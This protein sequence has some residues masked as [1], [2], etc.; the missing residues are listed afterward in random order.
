MRR[1]TTLL[2]RYV[3]VGLLAAAPA[4]AA[5]INGRIS[6]VDYQFGDYG[7]LA[8]ADTP[9]AVP[10]VVAPE[11]GG[12]APVVPNVPQEDQYQMRA[13]PP[14]EAA[15]EAEEGPTRYLESGFSEATGIKTYGWV[16][17]GIGANNWGAPFNGPITFDDRN[18]QG[19][20]NQL[21]L[22]NEK[23]L[24]TECSWF[25]WGGRI[26]LLYGTDYVFTT[27]RGLDAYAAGDP[28]GLGAPKWGNRYSGLAMPQLYGEFG[29]GDLAVKFGH[30]Y[31]II[32]YEVVP[33][34]GNFFYTHAYTMQYGEPFTHTGVLTTWTPNEQIVFYNG[35]TN[36]WDNWDDDML[37][38]GPIINDTYPGATS[39]AAYLGGVT[40]KN[41][42][43]SQSLTFTVTSGNEVQ[44]AII[45]GVVGNRSLYSLVYVNELNDCWTYVLQH[46]N[47]WQFNG[48]TPDGVETAQW[49]GINQYLFRTLNDCWT[50]GMRLEWFRDNDGT[51]VISGLRNSVAGV[52]SSAT[53]FEGNFWELTWGLNYKPNANWMVRPELRYDW[54]SPDIGYAGALPYGRG[55]NE[56]GQLYGGCDVIWQF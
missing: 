21:Y 25:D 3:A 43:A 44:N 52:P 46:D 54:F 40:F 36:G 28:L 33:A 37:T 11:S 5:D 23:V 49:Y 19:M 16:D 32:G 38:F 8:Q 10:S 12:R 22:V 14:Q 20:M 2:P 56:Y 15:A 31:T 1:I 26:D 6:P 9:A 30:F 7:A 39:N 42:D 51:R 27:A 53:G 17:A 55:F 24:D 13:L 29:F 47:G 50:A 48:L 4:M 35:I 45:G 41:A 34:I 18:W